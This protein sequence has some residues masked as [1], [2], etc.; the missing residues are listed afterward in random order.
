MNEKVINHVLHIV[1][2][3]AEEVSEDIVSSV[4][5]IASSIAWAAL[6]DSQSADRQQCQNG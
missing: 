4:D 3:H 1:T 5:S 2:G 6:F